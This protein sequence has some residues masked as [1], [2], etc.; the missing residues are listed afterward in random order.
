MS[1]EISLVHHE[2]TNAY[3]YSIGSITEPGHQPNRKRPVSTTE[4]LEYFRVLIPSAN[5]LVLFYPGLSV[6]EK[7]MNP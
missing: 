4:P 3:K 5:H 1:R 7:G 2:W 6:E